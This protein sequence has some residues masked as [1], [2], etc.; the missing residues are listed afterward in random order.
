MVFGLNLVENVKRL[1][2]I[3]NHIEVVIFHTPDLHNIPTTEEILFLKEIKA[4]KNLTYSV[5]LPASLEI[6]AES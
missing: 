5:H 6:A 1:S 2:R 4:E 3:V